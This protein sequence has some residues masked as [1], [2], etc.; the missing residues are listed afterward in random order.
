MALKMGFNRPF[1]TADLPGG[2]DCFRVETGYF[3]RDSL[4]IKHY[5]PAGTITDGAS[6]PSFLWPLLG[7]PRDTDVGQAAALHD[8]QYRRGYIA[9]KRCDQILCEGMQCLGA[10]WLKRKAVYAGLQIGG[11][12]A[13]NR[14]RKYDARSFQC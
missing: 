12:V 1:I 9:K 4:A 13:W 3:F 11:W 6:V 5:V 10:S 14:Y 7:H 8:L 2:T